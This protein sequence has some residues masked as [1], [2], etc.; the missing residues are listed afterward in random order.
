[1]RK[2]GYFFKLAIQDLLKTYSINL[3][4]FFVEFEV[5]EVNTAI[6]LNW[7]SRLQSSL[8]FERSMKKTKYVLLSKQFWNLEIFG[9]KVRMEF[10]AQQ[11]WKSP[12]KTYAFFPDE[13]WLTN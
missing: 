1:M 4:F 13:A 6:F 10:V 7:W 5:L 11:S 8:I 3:F 2:Q 9:E 12:P